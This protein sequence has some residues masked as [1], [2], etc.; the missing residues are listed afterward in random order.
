MESPPFVAAGLCQVDYSPVTVYG[1]GRQHRE[2]RRPSGVSKKTARRRTV[3]RTAARHRLPPCTLTVA[4]CH[5]VA[6]SFACTRWDA[7]I[8]AVEHNA[9]NGATVS[10]RAGH[11]RVAVQHGGV[12]I[13]IVLRRSLGLDMS[14]KKR[15]HP[16]ISVWAA[17]GDVL[18]AR[19]TIAVRRLRGPS[20]RRSNHR[21]AM[22]GVRAA[23]R[24]SARPPVSLP[25]CACDPALYNSG[26]SA[27]RRRGTSERP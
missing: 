5:I 6:G 27:R 21:S 26:V 7:L 18:V 17:P 3:G 23:R 9:Q 11:A 2:R 14:N 16:D 8:E 4:G 1:R 10:E 19:V 25:R 12:V 15:R 22:S 20:P 24:E 13:C